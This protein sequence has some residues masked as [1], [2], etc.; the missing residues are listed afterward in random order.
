MLQSMETFVLIILAI[1]TAVVLFWLIIWPA[2][3]LL[4]VAV[5]I[6]AGAINGVVQRDA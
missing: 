4:G 3:L 1:L 5:A 6:V 2:L